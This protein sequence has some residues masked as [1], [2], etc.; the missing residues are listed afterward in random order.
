MW[1]NDAEVK[2]RKEHLDFIRGYTHFSLSQQDCF[3]CDYKMELKYAYVSRCLLACSVFV[4]DIS[5]D[6]V[7]Y[8]YNFPFSICMSEI[9]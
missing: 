6:N 1:Q 8:K 9:L 3:I 4:C 5:L 7:V 2:Q